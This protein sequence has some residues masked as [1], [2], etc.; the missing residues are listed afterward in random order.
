[1]YV[2]AAQFEWCDDPTESQ[3]AWQVFTALAYG[4][5]GI[6]WFFYQNPLPPCDRP[7]LKTPGVVDTNGS[8]T[9][10]YY[11]AQR[12]N[13]R[14]KAL[15]Q[16][17]MQLQSTAVLQ[18]NWTQSESATAAQLLASPCGL[19]S[20]SRNY[21]TVGC[22]VVPPAA[23][24]HHRDE[25]GANKNHILPARSRAVFIVNYEHAHSALAKLAFDVPTAHVQEVDQRT[26]ELVPIADYALPKSGTG[27][28]GTHVHF[29]PGMGR[30]F[31]LPPEPFLATHT[32]T[33]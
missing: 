14:A 4:S 1:M 13:S 8:P 21:L 15:G 19:T 24:S 17:L 26:G 29:G 23:L 3:I 6:M 20:V 9:E 2:N 30:L 16:T 31:V 10:K 18:L 27:M 32:G 12:I 7:F 25:G 28:N 11:Q 22:F 5:R 33:E